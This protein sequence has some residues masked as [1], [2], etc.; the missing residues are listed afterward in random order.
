MGEFE[1]EIANGLFCETKIANS[2]KKNMT[3]NNYV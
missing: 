3:T 2:K 1:R